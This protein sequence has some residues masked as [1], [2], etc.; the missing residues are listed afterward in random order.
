M[1]ADPWQMHDLAGGPKHRATLER[2]APSAS[3]GWWRTAT[4]ACSRSM[5]FTS[6]PRRIRRS[7]WGWIRIAT[8]P[9]VARRGQPGEPVDA[10]SIPRLCELLKA[11][12]SA[13][14][15]VGAP[16]ACSRWVQ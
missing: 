5:S 9:A 12:D 1:Q 16:L 10:A 2:L 6:G 15:L 4:S 3:A 7:K 13:V 14:R 8:H 11:D